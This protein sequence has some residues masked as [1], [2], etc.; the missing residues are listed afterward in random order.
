MFVV[1]NKEK[2]KVPIKIWLDSIEDI[3]PT[4]LAQAETVSNHP[5][6]FRHVALMPDT[7]TGYA[8]PIGGV[9]AL[10]HCV[11]PYFVGVDI[12]CGMG[13]VRTNIK[14]ENISMDQIQQVLCLLKKMVPVG[15]NHH[16]VGSEGYEENKAIVEKMVDNFVDFE[17]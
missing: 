3:E 13:A 16:N 2:Q 7:H 9:A 1:Y 12:G 17:K 6:I 14:I 10:K 4:C 15:F 8:L 11:S 5:A